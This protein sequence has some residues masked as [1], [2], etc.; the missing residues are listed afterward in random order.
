MA[1]TVKLNGVRL[2]MIKLQ[3]FP[4]SL[5]DIAATWFESLPYGSINAWE[6]LVEAYLGRFFPPPLTTERR[7]EIIVFK[8]GE[9]ESLYTAWE[10]YKRL[11]KRCPMH[12]IDLKTQMDIVYHSLND[13][14]KGI[15][16]AT[17]CGAF[18]RRN[19]EEARQ[20]IEDL[21]KCNMKAPSESSV[22][23]SRTKGSGVIELNKMTAMEAKLDAIMHKLE[24]QE[25]RMHSAHEIGAV[26]RDGIIRSVEGPIDEDLYQVE[27]VNYLNEQRSYHFK[28]NPNLPTHYTPALR[29]H[30]TF[31]YGGGA[32]QSPRHGQGFQQGYNPP[33]FQQQQ[34]QGENINEY[35]GQKRTQSFEEQMLQFIGDNKKLL[36][37]HE[38]KFSKLE[39]FKSNTQIFQENTNASL[40]NLET[41]VRKLAST[42]QN[43]TKDAFPSDT[44]K[45]PRDCMA[46]QLRSGKEVNSS[47]VE[48]K[49]RSEQEEVE[50]TEEEDR[51]NN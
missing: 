32:S 31:S 26:E 45:N 43:Q 4:F 5:R 37:L 1:N 15:I 50:E 46:V 25:K 21:A 44:Q 20:L 28:P 35:Q 40:K 11:L 41:Q 9:D 16:D 27:E 23:N 13:T 19:A 42:L 7:R 29:G 33:R 12:G 38:H 17:C 3:L 36:N 10:R 51:K 8:Q 48:K 14:S 47:R 49:E 6:D 24:N 34:Q 18:K 30:E 2:E 39:T 22:N